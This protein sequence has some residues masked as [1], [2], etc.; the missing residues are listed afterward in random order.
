MPQCTVFDSVLYKLYTGWGPRY[1]AC[2]EGH[3]VLQNA[4]SCLTPI[5][6][7]T[8]SATVTAVTDTYMSR[9][10]LLPPG[11]LVRVCSLPIV[12]TELLDNVGK[13]NWNK[14]SKKIARVWGHPLTPFSQ[15][16]NGPPVTYINL[17]GPTSG[18]RLRAYYF[19][20][21]RKWF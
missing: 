7:I 16:A 12:Y 4:H 1:D 8:L 11:C 17:Q 14:K 13:R 19:R 15:I 9:R 5:Q 18:E 10:P 2:F 3:V 20:F 6:C 21:D